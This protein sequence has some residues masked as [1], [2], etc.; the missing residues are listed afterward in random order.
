MTPGTRGNKNTPVA[1]NGAKLR[2]D[3]NPAIRMAEL[4]GVCDVAV[5]DSFFD[6]ELVTAGVA[7]DVEYC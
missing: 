2:R 4:N 1:S 5:D 6:G 3:D 7:G